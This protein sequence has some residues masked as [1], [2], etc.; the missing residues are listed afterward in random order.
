[1]DCCSSPSKENN[2]MKGGPKK[3][4]VKKRTLLW[5]MIAFLFLASLFLTFKASSI[6]ATSVQATASTAKTAASTMVGG[7]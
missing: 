4:Q 5:V 7:C 1:M 6:G 3:M 2:E